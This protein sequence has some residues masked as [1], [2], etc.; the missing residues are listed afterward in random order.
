MKPEKSYWVVERVDPITMN[1][2]AA[3]LAAAEGGWLT[4]GTI[5]QARRYSE[6]EA[7]AVAE[8]INGLLGR[9]YIMSATG[10]IDCPTSETGGGERG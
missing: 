2:V 8:A 4:L 1:H 3:Y 7:K 5:E 9:T 6:A 10:H